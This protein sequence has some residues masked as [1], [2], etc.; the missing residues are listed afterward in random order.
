MSIKNIVLFSTATLIWGSTWLAIKFQLGI[1]DPLIS[2]FYRFLLASV[3]LFLFI[4]VTKRNVKFSVK[5]HLLM[6][7]QGGLLFGI[8][9][10][11]V[12]LAELNLTS[13]LVAIVFSTIVFFNIFFGAIFINAKIRP[14][15]LFGAII[16]FTGIIFIFNDE[17]FNFTL[18]SQSS[19]ALLIAALGAITASLG[20][21]VS[22]YNQKKKIPVI[23][24]NA[25]G[26][27]YG[28]VIMF[29]LGLMM[30]KS[31]RFDISLSYILSLLYLA[32]F[33]SVI[34][35]GCYLSLLGK[36]GADKVG[37]ATL[38]IPIIAIIMSTIFEGYVWNMYMFIG[39]IFILIGNIIVLKKRYK[40]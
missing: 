10:W 21:I 3:I 29:I 24:S 14:L 16:G 38:V 17:I 9:Y 28:S 31:I 4:R 39:M 23:Q 32:I 37:Y 22:A 6:C 8:N 34:A 27:L 25:F 15:V 18:S 19:I 1:V 5:E 20:N 13:G 7:L 12:Y 30:N 36:I 26:M 2:V 11:L 33:G 35:F 40:H